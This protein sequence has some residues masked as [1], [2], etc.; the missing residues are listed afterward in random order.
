MSCPLNVSQKQ[1]KMIK[2]IV[3]FGIVIY[4]QSRACMLH[5]YY[6]IL[7]TRTSTKNAAQSNVLSNLSETGWQLLELSCS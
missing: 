6:L 3:L 5:K 2:A 4:R 7:A 1:L